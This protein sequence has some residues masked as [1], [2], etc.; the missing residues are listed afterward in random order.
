MWNLNSCCYY[1][2]SN[3]IPMTRPLYITDVSLFNKSQF[4]GLFCDR[5]APAVLTLLRPDSE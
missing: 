3:V 5:P 2:N 4:S 1:C